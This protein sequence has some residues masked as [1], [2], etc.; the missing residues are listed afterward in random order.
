MRSSDR[1]SPTLKE[2]EDLESNCLASETVYKDMDSDEL[3]PLYFPQTIVAEDGSVG[4]T[5]GNIFCYHCNWDLVSTYRNHAVHVWRAQVWFNRTSAPNNEPKES[6]YQESPYKLRI[7]KLHPPFP[8]AKRFLWNKIYHRRSMP[9][10]TSSAHDN[11][12]AKC[13][14][15]KHS[16]WIASDGRRKA[17]PTIWSTKEA[18]IC[19]TTFQ[20][21]LVMSSSF[22][23][24]CLVGGDSSCATN[25]RDLNP[26]ELEILITEGH[27]SNPFQMGGSLGELMSVYDGRYA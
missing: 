17:F 21:K 12:L 10:L 14:D 25:L 4:P 6:P 15:M 26:E 1:T 3:L 13:S 7:D 2:M 16:E 24:R 20:S 9:C 27:L 8:L 22:L 11:I 23:E 5:Y 18:R 19:S